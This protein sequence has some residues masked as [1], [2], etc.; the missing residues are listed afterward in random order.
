MAEKHRNI[1][2]IS[3]IKHARKPL[4]EICM[5]FTIITISITMTG[6]KF[7]SFQVFYSQSNQ[8]D[9]TCLLERLNQLLMH[10]MMDCLKEFSLGKSD[11]PCM[12]IVWK[13]LL[14]SLNLPDILRNYGINVHH[15]LLV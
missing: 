11:N 3:I 1:K 13:C 5:F 2:S 12:R 10:R 8:L 7:V 9:Y 15:H 14:E 6:Q 4:L